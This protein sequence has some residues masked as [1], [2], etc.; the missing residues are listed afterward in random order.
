MVVHTGSR[1][2]A[3]CLWVGLWADGALKVQ[4]L[5]ERGLYAD[6][7]GLY[8]QVTGKSAKSWVFRFM[9]AGRARMMGLGS[10]S[11]LSLAE[12]R[13]KAAECR[14]MRAEGTDPIAARA[15]DRGRE[16]VAAARA[17]TFAAAAEQFIASHKAG[18]RN[19]KHVAQWSSTLTTYAGPAFGELPVQAVDTTL[20]LQALEPIWSTK[21][22]TASRVRGRVEAVLDW[23]TVRGYRQGEN[24]ARWRGHLDKLLPA[25]SKVQAVKHHAALPYVE[26]AAFVTRLRS[27]EAVSSRALEFTVLTA[28][29]SGEAL[30]ARWEEIDEAQRVWIVP[31]SRMKAGK[32]HRVPLTGPALAVLAEMRKL[33][34]PFIFPGQR[35]GKP[36]SVMAMDM[37]LRRLKM[38]V[39]VHGFRSSFRDWAA[40]RSSFP[41]EVVEMAL[42]HAIGS[43]VE[44]A[45][46]RGDLFEKRRRLMEA[47]AGFCAS[48]AGDGKVVAIANRGT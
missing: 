24:P 3:F 22:E 26:V 6:G 30:G 38:D 27:L 31:A 41:S 32:E 20:V 1:Q 25:R 28:A 44:A 37:T 29:R 4:R 43:K 45:Y 11:A 9:L 18:W 16:R 48:S 21:P 36:L 39:T 15:A 10:L 19:P 12:A 5:A 33:R 35:R 23:A 40:E 13:I 46:R 8:L 17:V 14:K 2:T 42:A 47:W 7:G 34:Q